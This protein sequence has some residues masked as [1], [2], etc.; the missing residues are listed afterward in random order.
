MKIKFLNESTNDVDDKLDRL[1]GEACESFGEDLVTEI[2][3]E[4]GG[5]TPEENP[6][7]W[8]TDSLDTKKFYHR[9]TELF[10]NRMLYYEDFEDASDMNIFVYNCVAEEY[11]LPT[12]DDLDSLEYMYDP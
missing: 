12:S 2:V 10:L 3:V 8:W 6:D 11:G 5:P 4:C 9:L 1:Y 7:G